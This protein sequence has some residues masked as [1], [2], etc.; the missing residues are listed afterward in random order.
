MKSAGATTPSPPPLEDFRRHLEDRERSSSTVSTYLGVLGQF[1]RWYQETT[2]EEPSPATITTT[3]LKE[4]KQDLR[5]RRKLAPATVNKRLAVLRSFLTWAQ[6]TGRLADG[7]PPRVP[8]DVRQERPAPRWLD[9]RERLALLRAVER[10]GRD[11]DAALLQVLLHTG[12]RVGELVAL[13]WSDVYLSPRKGHLVVRDGKGG[14]HREVPLNKE[15]RDAL[16][17]L[18]YAVGAGRDEEIFRGQRGPLTT[19]AVQ[20]LVRRY[21][22]AA[23]LEDVTP[24][25]L[26]HTFCKD[27]IDAGAHLQEVAAL[28]GHENLNTTRRYVEPSRGDLQGAVDRLTE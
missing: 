5:V 12:L 19:R 7:R 23:G 8:K 22:D 18:G 10:S 27:L 3:D 28:A 2:G 1:W 6:A 17:A 4:Y 14:K 11:R 20:Q 9:R 21:G 24:H 25:V 16:V 13:E 26:R 15:A